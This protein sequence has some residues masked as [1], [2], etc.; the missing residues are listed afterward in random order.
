M[1]K[2]SLEDIAGYEREKEE[3]VKM[4]D[5]LRNRKALFDKGG[6]IPKGLILYGP[7][8]NGKTLFAKVLA[9]EAGVDFFEFDVSKPSVCSRL[10]KIFK[11]ASKKSHAIIFIDAIDRILKL[12]YTDDTPE[13]VTSVLATLIDGFSTKAKN[14]VFVVG[15]TNDY[16]GIPDAI[17]RP[18]RIDKKIFIDRP[19]EDSRREILKLYLGKTDCN[20]ETNLEKMVKMTNKFSSAAIKTLVNEC[21]IASTDDYFV[22]NEVFERKV[23]EILDEDIGVD[24]SEPDAIITAYAELGRFVVARSLKNGEYILNIN[25]QG[26]SSGSIFSSCKFSTKDDEYDDYYDYDDEDGYDYVDEEESSDG[27]TIHSK[28]DI[29]DAIMI[30]MGAVAANT[31]FNSGP[32]TIDA[33]YIKKADSLAKAAIECGFYGLENRICINSDSIAYY[34]ISE[35]LKQKYETLVADI[36]KDAYEKA[37]NIIKDKHEVFKVLLPLLVSRRIMDSDEVEPLVKDFFKKKVIISE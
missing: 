36:L 1:K 25:Q 12:N 10:K 21:I 14:S 4:V 13:K 37:R 32:Y 29:I 16:E 27:I 6:Y 33:E 19:T 26:N 34:K 11:A 18:G 8:G 23:N 7:P 5:I 17:V 31:L 30:S 35:V 15:T 20:F 9:A 24:I 3:L 2:Y 22:S 28:R